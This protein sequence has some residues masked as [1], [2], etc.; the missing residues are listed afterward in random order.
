ALGFEHDRHVI[1]R[2]NVRPGDVLG[3]ANG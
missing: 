1:E 2:W 3:R